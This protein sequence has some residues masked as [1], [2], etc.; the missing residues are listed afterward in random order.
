MADRVNVDLNGIRHIL[1]S[2]AEGESLAKF[3]G[4]LIKE[5]VAQ[6]LSQMSIGDLIERLNPGLVAS[7]C[8]IDINRVADLIVGHP[9]TNIEI[10]KIA[11]YLRPIGITAKI[12]SE[13]RDREFPDHHESPSYRSGVIAQ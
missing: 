4:E 9:P 1:E 10:L 7:N 5:A 12:L 2:L 13:M 11:Q 3:G 6:R 8:D